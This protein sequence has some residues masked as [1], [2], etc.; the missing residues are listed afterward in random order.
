[1][2]L[3]VIIFMIIFFIGCTIF[4][5]EETLLAEHA[6]TNGDKIQIYFVAVGATAQDNIQVRKLPDNKIIASF[7]KY[8]YLKGSYLIND[9]ILHL[10][11]IDTGYNKTNKFDTLTV[12]VK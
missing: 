11:L 12:E 4:K 9:S 3:N 1:M 7:E 5:K 2:K 8:N 6:L 10:I